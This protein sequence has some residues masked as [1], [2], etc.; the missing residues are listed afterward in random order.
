M[1]YFII[2]LLTTCLLCAAP[3]VAAG[4]ASADTPTMELIFS[5]MEKQTIQR[6]YKRRFGTKSEDNRGKRK[7]KKKGNKGEHKGLPPG[8][9][10]RETLPPGLAKQLQRNGQLPPGLA[11]RDLPDDLESLLPQR[12]PGQRRVLVDNK[13]LLI[14]E[15]TGVILDVL[16]GLF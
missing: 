6:Y 4:P 15:A 13:V 10:K 14:E 12:L 5:E 16:E 8:L 1:N 7:G 11:K 3:V 9:A 2:T